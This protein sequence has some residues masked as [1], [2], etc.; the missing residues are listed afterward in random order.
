[1]VEPKYTDEAREGNLIAEYYR[2]IDSGRT[3]DVVFIG[4]CEAYSS[5]APPVL[6]ERYGIRSFVRG[7]PS[8]SIAQSYYL[9]CET[10]KYERP[11]AV[12]FSVYAMCKEGR[13]TEAYNRLTL[14]GMRLSYE[15]LCAVQKSANDGESALSYY[16]P[17]LR[18]HSRVF[19]LLESDIKYLFTRPRIS[20]NGYLLEKR[21]VPFDEGSLDYSTSVEDLP[22]EN[23]IY[24]D[25]MREE[26]L[27]HGVELILV[28]APV[29]SWRYPWYSEW[30]R[31]ISD[32]AAR[33]GLSYYNLIESSEEIGIDMLTDSYDGGLHLNVRGAENTSL[34]FGGLL[35][36]SHGITGEKNEYWEEKVIR[37]YN[38]RNDE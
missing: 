3:H 30:D 28:K 21:I 37:Y 9:L 26:C 15:K 33:H 12:I 14:D 6:Y 1:L 5:F 7:S 18:F 35:S 8:Q 25:K 10:L 24:L 17:L 23:F 31:A 19:E 4:D 20:H 16:I 34:Y 32:Y 36:R 13:S 22:Q 38:E 11:H 29:C 27:R 2:E